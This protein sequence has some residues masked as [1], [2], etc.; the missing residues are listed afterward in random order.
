MSMTWFG[1][2]GIFFYALFA[3]DHLYAGHAANLLW[4]C[5]VGALLVGLGLV[6]RSPTWNAIGLL[7]LVAGV[8]LWAMDLLANGGGRPTTLLTHVGGLVLGVIGVRRLG[9]P[10][11]TWLRAAIALAGLHLLCRWVTPPEENI[12]LAFTIWPGWEAYFP[13]HLV[14]VLTVFALCVAAFMSV[15]FAVRRA[16]LLPGSRGDQR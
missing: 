8:P 5:Q 10:K 7:W 14:Y 11:R 4:A 3:A 16:G 12:N 15:E 9:L 2:L 1:I 6:F 13:S